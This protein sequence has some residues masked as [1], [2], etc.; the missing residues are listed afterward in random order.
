MGQS[1]TRIWFAAN[2]IWPVDDTPER[3]PKGQQIETLITLKI[4]KKT[5]SVWASE[6]K[7]QW[8]T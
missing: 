4:T 5:S 2:I 3:T 8:R 7:R 6:W 1:T